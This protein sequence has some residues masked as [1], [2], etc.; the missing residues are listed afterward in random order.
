MENIDLYN[1]FCA[2]AREI[3]TYRFCFVDK[4]LLK[5]SELHNVKGRTDPFTGEWPDHIVDID[6]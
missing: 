2:F 6:V 5:G 4:K 1:S 3:P